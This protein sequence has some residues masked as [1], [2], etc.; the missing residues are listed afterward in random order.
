MRVIGE[1]IAIY[2][3][4]AIARLHWHGEHVAPF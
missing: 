2:K 3:R 4:E 1:L